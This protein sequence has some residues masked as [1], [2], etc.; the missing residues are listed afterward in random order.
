MKS[1]LIALFICLSYAGYGQRDTISASGDKVFLPVK[2]D[3]YKLDES[4]YG[5]SEKRT[6]S[7]DKVILPVKTVNK[8]KFVECQVNFIPVEFIFDT[9][10]SLTTISQTTFLNL[11]KQGL[12]FDFIEEKSFVLAN[13]S[14]SNADI[15]NTST[16][17]IG[18]YHLRD[19]TFAVIH[20][21]DAPNL[22]GQNVFNHFKSYVIHDKYIELFPA[23]ET[24]YEENLAYNEENAANFVRQMVGMS[25]LANLTWFSVLRP[26][27]DFVVEDAVLQRNKVISKNY[28]SVNV[29]MP[30]SVKEFY[31]Y[32]IDYKEITDKA[33]SDVTSGE[34]CFI[35]IDD[36]DFGYQQFLVSNVDWIECNF[37]Y[38]FKNGIKE[39]TIILIIDDLFLSQL[40]LGTVCKMNYY[41]EL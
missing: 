40:K 35:D 30:E 23:N 16:F 38:Q 36:P 22:L 12:S 28:V 34:L 3:K 39:D 21:S 33:I 11:I 26:S 19:I 27:I 29:I 1:V 8:L 13:G 2:N 5:E 41:R 25:F 32:Q 9:G 17:S 15:Y 6:N 20:Q 37:V 10:A 14:M 31:S 4:S 24:N 7:T 18:D